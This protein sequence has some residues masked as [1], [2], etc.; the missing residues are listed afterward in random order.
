MAV[1]GAL[2]LL[3]ALLALVWFASR[4]RDICVLSVRRGRVLVMRGGLPPSLVQALA[5]VVE[6]AGTERATIRIQREGERGRVAATG[7][8]DYTLQRA[9]NVVGTYPLARLLAGHGRRSRNL[10]QQLGLPWLAWRISEREEPRRR[11]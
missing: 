11:T 3:L 1:L 4:A 7:L 10:G 6:R 9:R 5:D 8:D 2:V